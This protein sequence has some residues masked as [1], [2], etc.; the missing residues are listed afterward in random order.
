MRH[1]ACRMRQMGNAVGVAMAAVGPVHAGSGESGAGLGIPS[2]R[3]PERVHGD[4]HLL[5]W[6]HRGSTDLHLNGVAHSLAA[7]HV[8]W[9]PAGVRHRLSV[10]PESVV[11]PVFV[12]LGLP[13][14]HLRAGAMWPVDDDFATLLLAM[15]QH[16]FSPV[17]N[18]G[19]DLEVQLVDRITGWRQPGRPP[20]P[21]SREAL[22]V[23]AL[24]LA[25][26]AD[27]RPLRDL[28]AGVFVSQRTVERQFLA[29]TGLTLQRWRSHHRLAEALNRLCAGCPL[30]LAAQRAGYQDVTA[31]RRAFKARYGVPPSRF[32]EVADRFEQVTAAS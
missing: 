27:P 1:R 17:L 25:D 4:C 10:G 8:C 20:L 12:R 32:D 21:R 5:L 16:Q 14:G 7:G 18:A 30:A 24:L 6:Q 26:P 31:F 22:E 23:A 2:I 19:A 29:E 3:V 28:V 13:V 9:V 15:V 11:L